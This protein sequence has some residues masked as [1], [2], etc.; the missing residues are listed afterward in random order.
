MGAFALVALLAGGPLGMCLALAYGA[1]SVLKIAKVDAEYAKR[2]ET[3]PSHRLVEK[4]LE[5]RKARGQAPA[6]ARPAKYGMW[7][8]F[9]QRWQAM[10][11][12]ATQQHKLQHEQL[13]QQRKAAAAAGQPPPVRRSRR[14]QWKSA[15]QWLIEGVVAPPSGKTPPNPEPAPQPA[16]P[17]PATGGRWVACDKCGQ[18]LVQRAGH[19]DHPSS[20]GCPA[21]RQPSDEEPTTAPNSEPEPTPEPEPSEAPASGSGYAP[22]EGEPM[23]ASTPQ[24][25]Q[26]SGE[27]VG[28]MSAINYAGAV[29]AAHEAHSLGGGEQYMASLAQAEVGPETIRSAGAAQEAS[30]NAA[31]AWRAHETKLKEQLAAKEATTSETGKKNF[32][33]AE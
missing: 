16:E 30:Q 20:A 2:G 6:N 14:E 3:P 1:V 4:W 5:G 21:D 24:S 32:L 12:L 11:E 25:T 19:W 9:A 17:A 7:R 22:S 18:T 8:Y 28:L 23:T 15:W 13:L 29:A 33:L 31:G 26:Q 10:W 27:V